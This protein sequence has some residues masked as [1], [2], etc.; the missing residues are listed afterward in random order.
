MS[1]TICL[2]FLVILSIYFSVYSVTLTLSFF[3]LSLYY[4]ITLYLSFSL[5]ILLFLT[6]Y[7]SLFIFILHFYSPSF[8]L[9][10]FSLFSCFYIYCLISACNVS[11]QHHSVRAN[12][13]S[14]SIIGREEQLNPSLPFF[15]PSSHRLQTTNYTSAT[16]NNPIKS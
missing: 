13:L 3:S 12:H 10:S 7:L 5:S 9:I 14:L 8:S 4:S 11:H 1:L 2:P 15:S 16:N 6:F